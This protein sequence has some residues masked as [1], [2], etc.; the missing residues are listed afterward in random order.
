MYSHLLFD[1]DG[2]LTDSGRGIMN[3]AAYALKKHGVM[4]T[5]PAELRKFI[6]PPLAESFMRFA[7]MDEEEAQAA[8]TDYREY[9]VP[10]GIFENEV[11]DGIPALLTDLKASGKKLIGPRKVSIPTPQPATTNKIGKTIRFAH[12]FVLRCIKISSRKMP[13]QLGTMPVYAPKNK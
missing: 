1:L 10:Y 2:T 4:L 12:F 13:T 6:G 5:D 8:V 9:F 3:S 11:Y 7:G